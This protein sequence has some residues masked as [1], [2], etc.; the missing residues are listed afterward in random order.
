[1]FA[2]QLNKNYDTISYFCQCCQVGV[3]YAFLE[4]LN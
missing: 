2:G 3:Q 4:A 1:M